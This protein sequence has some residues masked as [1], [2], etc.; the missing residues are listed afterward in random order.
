MRPALLS[1]LGY[2]NIE[3]GFFAFV[4]NHLE[5]QDQ[6]TDNFKRPCTMNG[7]KLVWLECLLEGLLPSR[8]VLEESRFPDKP[9]RF[10]PRQAIFRR[11]V[12]PSS[13]FP[14]A[15]LAVSRFPKPLRP[16]NTASEKHCVRETL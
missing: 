3:P 5:F 10:A 13:L 7:G 11:F 6:S 14:T 8:S 12:T 4:Q 9:I 16:R 1:D 2:L 15:S